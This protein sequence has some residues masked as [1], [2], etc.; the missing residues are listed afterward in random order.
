MDPSTSQKIA[1]IAAMN[2]LDKLND[3]TK[4]KKGQPRKRQVKKIPEG[5][6][7][8]K[9]GRISGES[10]QRGMSKL[11]TALNESKKRYEKAASKIPAD[12]MK[13]IQEKTKDNNAR[14]R[15]NNIHNAYMENVATP[16]EY[17][18]WEHKLYN[19]KR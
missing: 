6:G 1:A 11:V 3:I 9:T 4:L 17:A 2:K 7:V 10:A 19:V 14:K 18:S 16:E 5:K 8:K 12:K 15:K 13:R